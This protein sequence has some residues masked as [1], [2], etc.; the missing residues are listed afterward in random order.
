MTNI[1]TVY[2]SIFVFTLSI[3][4]AGCRETRKGHLEPIF[5]YGERHSVEVLKG[6]PQP[7][8]FFREFVSRE[9]PVLFKDAAKNFPAFNKWSDEFF[10]SL[11]ES[12]KHQVTVETKKKENRLQP[13]DEVSFRTFL[14]YYHKKDIYMVESIPEFLR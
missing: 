5:S 9:K 3:S 12:K 14:K 11:P 2:G 4:T 10:I 1:F 6:F 13:A 8:Q 7:E